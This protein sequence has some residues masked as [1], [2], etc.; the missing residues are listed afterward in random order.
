MDLDNI[1]NREIT[2]LFLY[3][4]NNTYTIDDLD[5]MNE[6]L[7]TQIICD[8]IKNNKLRNNFI[9][10][11]YLNETICIEAV[12][13]QKDYFNIP[14]IVPH[15]LKTENY[16]LAFVKR[17]C[18]YIKDIPVENLTENICLAAVSISEHLIR[19]VPKKYMTKN[20]CDLVK[21]D[22]VREKYIDCYKDLYSCAISS[23]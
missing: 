15:Y 3:S 20:V 11:R 2:T 17:D 7:R 9:P 5:D 18:T 6:F 19:Y 1:F 22:W 14:A 4:F 23:S 16:Y 8:A 10:D 21:T 12:K 13:Y